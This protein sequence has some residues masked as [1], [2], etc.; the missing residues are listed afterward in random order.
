MN[1][2]SDVIWNPI[3]GLVPL[4]Q[5]STN[6]VYDLRVMPTEDFEMFIVIG[7]RFYMAFIEISYTASKSSTV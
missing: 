1:M 5:N 4:A 2:P 7:A 3:Q 6:Y